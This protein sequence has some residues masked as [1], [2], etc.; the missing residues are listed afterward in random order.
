MVDFE[1]RFQ[2]A[3]GRAWCVWQPFGQTRA[4]EPQPMQSSMFFNDITLI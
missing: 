3:T 4:Q 1:F 2:A